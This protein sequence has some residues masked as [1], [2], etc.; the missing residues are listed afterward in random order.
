MSY[1]RIYLN[2][3]LFNLV[4]EATTIALI[5]LY[6]YFSSTDQSAPHSKSLTAAQEKAEMEDSQYQPLL[7]GIFG[8]PLM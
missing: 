6:A 2:E 1:P 5:I 4:L 3:K 7:K 8:A